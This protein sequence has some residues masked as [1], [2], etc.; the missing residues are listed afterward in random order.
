MRICLYGAGSAK[1]NKKYL[2]VGY[3]LGERLAQE[4][5]TLV[6]GAGN[7]GMMGAVA[8][9]MHDN[10]CKIIG[11][12]PDWMDKFEELYDY[13]D[14]L[15]S[16]STMDERKR[17]FLTNSDLFIIAPGGIGTLDEFFQIIT[18]KKLEKHEKPIIMFNIDGYY[19][20]L[21]DMMSHMKKEKTISENDTKLYEVATSIDEI[22][23]YINTD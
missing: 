17:L 10:N 15:I 9:G 5:H 3:Q 13:C 20:V 19:D 21:L 7:N 11:I 14:K 6:F 8:R 23:N 4:N 22:L 18:L 2:D 1:L 16:T 12:S